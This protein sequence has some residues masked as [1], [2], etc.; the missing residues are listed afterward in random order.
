[1]FPQV[2]DLLQSMGWLFTFRDETLVFSYAHRVFR[3]TALRNLKKWALPIVDEK[4]ADEVVAKPNYQAPSILRTVLDPPS[5]LE[6]FTPIQRYFLLVNPEST[7]SR[8]GLIRM[9][10]RNRRN[11]V[12]QLRQILDKGILKVHQN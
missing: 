12:Q 11:L 3:L 2:H 8:T 5:W 1:M 10:I 7:A 6:S 4:A 9:V